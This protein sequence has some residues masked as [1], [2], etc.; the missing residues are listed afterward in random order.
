MSLQQP[1]IVSILGVLTVL[2]ALI[3]FTQK[4][5]SGRMVN[6][7]MVEINDNEGNSFIDR[8]E[9]TSL[10]NAE[11]TDYVLGLSVD[12]LNLKELERRVE[13]NAFVEDAEVYL[14]VEGNLQVQIKQAHPVARLMGTNGKSHYIDRRGNLLPLNTKHTARVP[15]VQNA[16]R[17]AWQK[18]IT[19]TAY[20][21]QLLEMLLY[22]EADPFWKAQI[23][24]LMLAKN[25]EITMVPQVTKQ[26]IVFG[27]PENL[28]SKFAKLSL[29]YKEILP[30]KGWNTYTQV[31]VKFNNQIVCK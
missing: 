27:A 15:V 29:F 23:A 19:E 11:N 10:I 17:E 18:N 1:K 14:D 30:V 2:F 12:Q 24:Q 5:Q 31:N 6:D 13:V 25:G 28:E 9:V 3:G 26:E 22:I 4:K 7:L 16:S 21:S 8:G 20:G